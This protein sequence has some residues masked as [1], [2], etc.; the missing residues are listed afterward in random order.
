M[1]PLKIEVINL[2]RRTSI[3]VFIIMQVFLIWCSASDFK[4]VDFLKHVFPTPMLFIP[5]LNFKT[6]DRLWHLTLF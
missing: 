3:N 2:Q 6:I 5:E 1:L 4:Y